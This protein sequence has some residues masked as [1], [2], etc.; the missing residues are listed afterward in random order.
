MKRNRLL[1]CFPS[2][3][4]SRGSMIWLCLSVPGHCFIYLL[5]KLASL[6][7]I[8]SKGLLLADAI[9]QYVK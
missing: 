7:R 8:Q 9:V 3:L 2:W 4:L 6:E 1:G 5:Y